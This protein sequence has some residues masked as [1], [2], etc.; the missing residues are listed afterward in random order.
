MFPNVLSVLRQAELES[1]RPKEP[2]FE[3]LYLTDFIPKE[4][5]EQVKAME[6]FIKDMAKSTEC[7]YRHI[8]IRDDWQGTAP[9]EE[10]DLRE[11]LYN[12]S[13]Q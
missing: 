5:P 9:V 6:D 8:S 7:N 4:N 11:Y 12:V 2:P 1:Q 10:K 3:I 13:A